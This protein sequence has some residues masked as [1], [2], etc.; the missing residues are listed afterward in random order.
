MRCPRCL[1]EYEPHVAACATCG[2]DLVADDAAPTPLV[3][4]RLGRFHPAVAERL[5]AMLTHR[6]V[7]HRRIDRDDEVELLVDR[8]WRDDLRAEL[9]LTW[10]Q[11]VAAL[12][13]ERSFEVRQLGG[14]TPGWFDAPAGGW[15]DR[16][17]RFA[18]DSDDEASDEPRIIGPAMAAIG[19]LVALLSWYT[20][21]GGGLTAT[22]LALLLA[23][24]LLPR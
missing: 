9:A 11:V 2:T 19:G 20:S 21:A 1:D 18:V 10:P 24:V 16:A 6:G 5:T 23:G 3:D 12:P 14:A 15:V 13:P 8:N 17:G 22:G 7:V 4:A